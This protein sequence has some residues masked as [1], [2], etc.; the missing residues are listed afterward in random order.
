MKRVLVLCT[1]NSCRSQM[2][3]GYLRLFS[4]DRAEI[5]SAGIEAHGVNPRAISAMKEDGIDISQHT[6]NRVEE[7]DGLNFDFVITVCDNAK[8]R[9]PIFPGTSRKFH[10]DFPDP[11]RARGTEEEIR[12]A[13]LSTRDLIREY[14][15]E[16]VAKQ[17]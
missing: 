17:L 11:A 1:G 3:E 9:C 6:S 2:A 15:R 16:F 13:F 12:V 5:Y 8:E 10:R 4:G 14:C 7:Y